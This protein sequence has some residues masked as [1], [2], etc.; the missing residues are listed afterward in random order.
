MEQD[1]QYLI[2]IAVYWRI[3][4]VMDGYGGFNCSS[5]SEM[6]PFSWLS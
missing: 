3:P 5:I 6:P 2:A 1:E 4:R